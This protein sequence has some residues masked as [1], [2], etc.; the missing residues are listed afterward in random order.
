MESVIDA[1]PCIGEAVAQPK[2]VDHFK[3]LNSLNH[4][5]LRPLTLMERVM[6]HFVLGRCSLGQTG[7]SFHAIKKSKPSATPASDLDGK[8]DAA[9]C[10]GEA[11]AQPKPVDHFQPLKNL[12]HQQLRPLTLKE[13]VMSHFVL[14]RLL[15]SPNQW[16]TSSH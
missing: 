3:P 16:I 1:A 4:Q 10:V 8:R 12:N 5:Q 2:P 14:V 6:P 7:G 13:S 9:L 15:P 11:V